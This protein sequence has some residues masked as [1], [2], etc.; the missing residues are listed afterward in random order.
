MTKK[1]AKELLEL[2]LMELIKIAN[3]ERKKNIKNNIELCCIMNAKSGLCSEDCKFC[4]Q[5]AHHNTNIQVYPLRSKE[6][7]FE[8]AKKAKEIKAKKFGIVT[9]GNRL[10]HEE[11]KI[12]YETIKAI[13][14][15]IDIDVCAS[16]GALNCEELLYLK[17]AGLTRYHHNIETSRNFYPKIVTTHSFEERIETIKSVKKANLEVCSGGIIGLGEDWDDRID[18]AFILK[19]LNVDSIPINVLV[20]IDGTPME[21]KYLISA[22]DAIKTVALFR[23]IMPDKII[24]LAA[25]R[26][27]ILKDFQAMAFM[28]GV[29]GMLIG[30]YLTIRGRNIEEDYKL[31]EEI[32]KAW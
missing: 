18:M 31:I 17:E 24:K 6:E 9:S 25:G 2:P 1:E 13:K 30:G 4:A 21:K 5:S 20:P 19:E 7:I 3:E 14:N 10:N 27:T 29:N 15:K 12:I 8:E 26:E 32:L 11:L 28:A 22:I 16:L 23:I